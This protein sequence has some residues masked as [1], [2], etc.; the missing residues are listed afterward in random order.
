MDKKTNK[1]VCGACAWYDW[2]YVRCGLH[3]SMPL[4]FFM[5]A[6]GEQTRSITS[7]FPC[8]RPF[9]TDASTCPDRIIP[10]SKDSSR[11]DA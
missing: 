11:H 8:M 6:F 5:C 9:D 1:L 2:T 7:P 10:A 4:Y 3:D